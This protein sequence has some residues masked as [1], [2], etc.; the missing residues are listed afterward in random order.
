MSSRPAFLGLALLASALA[1]VIALE[2]GAG[3]APEEEGGVVATRHPPPPRVAAAVAETVDRTDSWLATSLARPL[4]SRDRRPTPVLSKSDGNAAISAI[5]RLSGVL[6]SPLGRH[7]I[8]AAAE[9]GK[10]IVVAAGGTFGPYTVEQ[11]EPGEVTV[12]GPDGTVQLRL[13]FDAAARQA[14]LEQSQQALAQQQA[15]QQQL[16]QQAQAQAAQAAQ[17]QAAQAAQAQAIAAAQA[18]GQPPQVQ[19]PLTPGQFALPQFGGRPG[20]AFQRGQ[21]PGFDQRQIP[22]NNN[23]LPSEHDK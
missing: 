15:A 23:N 18:Q 19:P 21:Q 17:L 2:V 7:A 14:A 13:A 11:I 20:L 10:P 9:G 3:D 12:S 4:F 16:A 1:G 6:V 22:I 8:F 5:P